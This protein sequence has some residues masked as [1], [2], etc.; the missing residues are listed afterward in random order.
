MAQPLY[1]LKDVTHEGK[2]SIVDSGNPAK[3]DLNRQLLKDLELHETFRDVR[4]DEVSKCPVYGPGPGGNSGLIL[5]YQTPDGRLPKHVMYS[6]ETEWT[7]VG[8]RVWIGID[9]ENPPTEEDIQRKRMIG[10][11]PL[12]I[13][14]Q[15][16]SIPI[17]RS[18]KGVTNLPADICR[19]QGIV[20]LPIRP[21][22]VK[23]W[24]RADDALAWFYDP[25]K[26]DEMGL[27][28]LAD[29]AIFNFSLNYR[30]SWAEQNVLKLVSTENCV[31]ILAWNTNV[32]YEVDEIEMG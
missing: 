2:G 24:K 28:E 10:G 32:P 3:P 26:Q 17:I 1:F 16:Y 12:D 22:Y 6:T 7:Q 23:W 30:Y 5:C 25:K 9:P 31:T 13:N 29:I 27:E 8:E 11:T 20:N 18:R 14:G 15:P 4:H 21:E 19:N